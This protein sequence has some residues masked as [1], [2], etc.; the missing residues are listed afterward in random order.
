[1]EALATGIQSFRNTEDELALH[2]RAPWRDEQIVKLR[3]G[4]P[5]DLE[6][7][8]KTCRGYKGHARAFAFQDRIGRDRRAV[9]HFDTVL[10][11]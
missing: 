2:K 6:H 1:M 3:P 8:F 11:R 9:H 4:L 10:P 7:V 5:P